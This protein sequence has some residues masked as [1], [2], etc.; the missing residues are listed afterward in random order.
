MLDNNF[1]ECEKTCKNISF[2]SGFNRISLIKMNA[3]C[4]SWGLKTNRTETICS[5]TY[6]ECATI[7]L[8]R[9]FPL[10]IQ[11]WLSIKKFT[12]PCG[13]IRYYEYYYYKRRNTL[14]EGVLIK[15]W[16]PEFRMYTI[17]SA[18]AM[19]DLSSTRDSLLYHQFQLIGVSIMYRTHIS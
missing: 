9:Q 11:D 15:S 1:D 19:R 8:L 5:V 13:L 3:R 16:I 7:R 18:S 14:D 12:R 2:P 10:H 4:F 6:S 17:I